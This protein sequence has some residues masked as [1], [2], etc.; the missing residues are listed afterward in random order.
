VTLVNIDRQPDAVKNFFATLALTP[1]GSLVEMNG[2]AVVHIIPATAAPAEPD[3]TEWT[4]QLNHRR[5]DLVDKK[6]AGGLTPVEEA[7]LTRLTA[8]LRHFVDRVA[9]VPLDEVRKLHQQLLETA[10]LADSQA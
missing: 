4:P 6:F 1:E 8:G 9:P 2:R 7:E 10:A 3:T 5:C